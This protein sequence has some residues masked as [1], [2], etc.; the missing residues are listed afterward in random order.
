LSRDENEKRYGEKYGGME[1]ETGRAME[2]IPIT[3]K[4][5]VRM[6]PRNSLFE[7]CR[8]VARVSDGVEKMRGL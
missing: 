1:M 5:A 3:G 7:W 4:K 2:K 8:L 6:A